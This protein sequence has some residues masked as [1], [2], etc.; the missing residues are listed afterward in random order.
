MEKRAMSTV[1]MRLVV[2]TIVVL[3]FLAQTVLASEPVKQQGTVDNALVTFRNFMV[4]KDMVWLQKN[5][6]DAKGILIIPNLL[7]AGFVWGGSGGTGVLVVR[8]EK[9]GEWSQPA[10]YT[11]GS[12]TFGLQ[13][14]GESAEV[15]MVVRTQKA[16]DA[17][18]TTEFKLGGDASIAAGPVGA[19]AKAAVKT[20][21]VSF[22]KSKGLFAGLNLEGSML[23][24]SDDSNK[25]YY[26]QAVSPVD[27]IVKKTVSNPGSDAL[28][29]E[30]KKAAK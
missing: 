18:F 2:L 3:A 5:L 7:K 26:N 6:K 20:D 11:I 8:D 17:L 14:G 22:A 30:L 25:A 19:G 28:R 16:L 27:I 13:I 21:I 23:K 9:T 1:F 15:I 24:V 4:D 12:V 29:N 10:F